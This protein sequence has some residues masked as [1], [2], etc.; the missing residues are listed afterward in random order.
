MV[1]PTSG[2]NMIDSILDSIKNDAANVNPVDS[3]F[4]GELILHINSA[5]AVLRQ[6]GVGPTTP[7]LIED[8]TKTWS[9]FTD[10]ENLL[11]LVKA[12]ISLRVR[13]MFDPPSSSALATAL[14]NS[15]S[16]YEWR[17][18]IEADNYKVEEDERYSKYITKLDDESEGGSGG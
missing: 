3:A 11:P 1:A 17:L 2:E 16:E 18:Q 9:E 5:F 10:D 13:K 12:Y 15:I 7:F 8:N 14:D 6:I 4:D